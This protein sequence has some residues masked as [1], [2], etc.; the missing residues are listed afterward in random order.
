MLI[1]YSREKIIVG[2]SVEIRITFQSWCTT[3]I[4]NTYTNRLAAKY[5]K[6]FEYT[7]YDTKISRVSVITVMKISN[8]AKGNGT[9]NWAADAIAPKSAPILIVF[10]INKIATH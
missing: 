2:M 5:F 10:A 4:V 8:I 3:N 6:Y 7:R 9:S 1:M